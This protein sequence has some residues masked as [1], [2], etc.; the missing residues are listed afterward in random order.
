MA[1][2]DVTRGGT[3][4]GYPAHLKGGLYRVTRELDFNKVNRSAADVLQ[5]INVPAN[6][7]VVRVAVLVTVVEGAT[8]TFDIGDGA[9]PAGY[10][11]AH[12]GNV[13]AGADSGGIV[14]ETATPDTIKPYSG[15]GKRYSAADTIDMTL[16]NDAASAKVTVIAFL[17]DQSS[18]E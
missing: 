3:G 1:T 6:T 7:R 14:L 9:T 18:A 16:D 4:G 8:L 12:D 10:I 11:E 2:V 15:T 13:L 17:E 5:L